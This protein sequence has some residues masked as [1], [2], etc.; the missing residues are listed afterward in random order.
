MESVGRNVHVKRDYATSHLRSHKFYST[1]V[2][3]KNSADAESVSKDLPRASWPKVILKFR[4]WMTFEPVLLLIHFSFPPIFDISELSS[5][6]R[7]QMVLFNVHYHI[8]VYQNQ[9]TLPSN[10][11]VYTYFK[12]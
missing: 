1:V 5:V 7:N 6:I 8:K 11:H 12:K 10:F 2:I 4:M 9:S 3:H